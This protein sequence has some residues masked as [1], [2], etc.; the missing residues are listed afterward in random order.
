MTPYQSFCTK[1]KNGCGSSLCSLGNKVVFARGHV[2][3][4][5]VFV[6][7]APGES[8]NVLGRPFVGPA[9]KLLDRIIADALQP[10]NGGI[11]Y[12]LTNLV[13]CIPRDEESGGK[14]AQPSDEDVKK[15]APRLQE[16][17]RLCDPRMIVAVGTLA[18]DWLDTK[19]R[20]HIAF[21]KAIPIIDIKHPAAI[22]RANV[23]NQG[24]DIQRCV[25]TIMTAVEDVIGYDRSYSQ[26]P[27]DGGG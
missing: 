5:L 19:H 14:L 21:H 8:E 27:T 2:P 16:F 3:C 24:L 4:D 1:W 7:E 10:W 26:S 15:C 12:A 18:R 20:G 13:G 25:V 23:A 17:V 22:L 6:G 9:G 11:R